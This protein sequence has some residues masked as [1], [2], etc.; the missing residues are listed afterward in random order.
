MISEQLILMVLENPLKYA[1]VSVSFI[2]PALYTR[3]AGV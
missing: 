3:A 2:T 1:Q